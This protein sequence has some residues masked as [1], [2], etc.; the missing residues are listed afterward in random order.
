[1]SQKLFFYP[2][3]LAL[4]LSLCLALPNSALALRPN[5]IKQQ[6]AGLEALEKALGAAPNS[7]PAAGME[8]GTF[9]APSLKVLRR[10]VQPTDAELEAAWGRLKREMAVIGAYQVLQFKLTTGTRVTPEEKARVERAYSQIMSQLSW[11]KVALIIALSNRHHPFAA[12]KNFSREWA[13]S[14]IGGS[15]GIMTQELAAELAG[16]AV[17]K[18]LLGKAESGDV[19]KALDRLAKSGLGNGD[20]RKVAEQVIADIQKLRKKRKPVDGAVYRDKTA[21]LYLAALHR[22]NPG[23]LAEMKVPGENGQVRFVVSRYKLLELILSGKITD[24]SSFG[25]VEGPIRLQPGER[26]L[27]RFKSGEEVRMPVVLSGPLNLAARQPGKEARFKLAEGKDRKVVLSNSKGKKR[28]LN[29]GR[30]YK[31]PRLFMVRHEPDGESGKPVL[32]LSTPKAIQSQIEEI[33][34]QAEGTAPE[35]KL[36]GAAGEEFAAWFRTASKKTVLQYGT[37]V[38]QAQVPK[39]GL[40]IPV[41][42][43]AA[44][45]LT[46]GLMIEIPG[47]QMVTLQWNGSGFDLVSTNESGEEERQPFKESGS[48]LTVK[49]TK[50]MK[51]TQDGDAIRLQ[52]IRGDVFLDDNQMESLRRGLQW[53]S[54]REALRNHVVDRLVASRSLGGLVQDSAREDLAREVGDLLFKHYIDRQVVDLSTDPVLLKI[55]GLILREIGKER[56]NLPSRKSSEFLT[57]LYAVREGL[58]SWGTRTAAGMEELEQW[59]AL[60]GPDLRNLRGGDRVRGPDDAVRIVSYSVPMEGGE[61]EVRFLDGTQITTA[62]VESDVWFVQNNLA[63]LEETRELAD[64]DLDGL[65]QKTYR[66]VEKVESRV[67]GSSLMFDYKNRVEERKLLGVPGGGILISPNA[68]REPGAITVYVVTDRIDKNPIEPNGLIQGILAWDGKGGFWFAD[69][70]KIGEGMIPFDSEGKFGFGRGES[71][72]P[73]LLGVEAPQHISRKHVAFQSIP[74]KGLLIREEGRS[75]ARVFLPRREI[76]ELRQVSDLPRPV[77]PDLREFL[78]ILMAQIHSSNE[79]ITGADEAK[80]LSPRANALWQDL[81]GEN[82]TH[83]DAGRLLQEGR[84]L[85]ADMERLRTNLAGRLNG[86]LNELEKTIRSIR[87][88][89][90]KTALSKERERLSPQVNHRSYEFMNRQLNGLERTALAITQAASRL[91]V[92]RAQLASDPTRADDP[93]V[94]GNIK[95]IEAVFRGIGEMADLITMSDTIP[96]HG[97]VGPDG[98]LLYL[99]IKKPTE[100][101]KGDSVTLSYAFTRRGLELDLRGIVDVRQDALALAMILYNDRLP[102]AAELEGGLSPQ[103]A[104]QKAEG[105]LK[106]VSKA[107]TINLV[108]FPKRALDLERGDAVKVPVAIQGWSNVPTVLDGVRERLL[109]DGLSDYQFQVNELPPAFPDEL[110]LEIKLLSGPFEKKTSAGLEEPEKKLL[111]KFQEKGISAFD[112]GLFIGMN[113]DQFKITPDHRRELGEE[114]NPILND[115]SKEEWGLARWEAAPD[116]QKVLKAVL[117]QLVAKMDFKEAEIKWEQEPPSPAAGLEEG[118]KGRGLTRRDLLVGTVGAVLGT[119]AGV[120]GKIGYDALTTPTPQPHTP[121]PAR[122]PPQVLTP[123]PISFD[124][125][126]PVVTDEQARDAADVLCS[127][128]DLFSGLKQELKGHPLYGLRAHRLRDG[129]TKMVD[130]VDP[131]GRYV[132]VIEW[133]HPNS[134][135]D[136]GFKER[137]PKGFLVNGDVVRGLSS[138]GR[139]VL[140]RVESREYLVD[141][142]DVAEVTPTVGLLRGDVIAPLGTRMSYNEL[143]RQINRVHPDT[144][145]GIAFSLVESAELL[146]VHQKD[147]GKENRLTKVTGFTSFGGDVYVR[148]LDPKRAYTPVYLRITRKG[149]TEVAE[150]SLDAQMRQELGIMKRAAMESH[151]KT[152]YMDAPENRP[153]MEFRLG[154]PKPGDDGYLEVH[155]LD[156]GRHISLDNVSAFTVRG[157]VYVKYLNPQNSFLPEY[158]RIMRNGSLTRLSEEEVLRFAPDVAREFGLRAGMEEV[159]KTEAPVPALAAPPTAEEARDML[160]E[161]IARRVIADTLLYLIDPQRVVDVADK[162]DGLSKLAENAGYRE[163]LARM[164]PPAVLEEAFV[165]TEVPVYVQQGWLGQVTPG[166][167]DAIDKKLI[168]WAK[169]LEEAAIVIGGDN[170]SI[171]RDQVLIQVNDQTA[172]KVTAGLLQYLQ[173]Q[174]LLEPGSIVVLHRLFKGGDFGEALLIF[175]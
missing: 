165:G 5:E 65:V 85:L 112:L 12:A 175:A 166:L 134:R 79:I 6:E 62:E 72:K 46:R 76:E 4:F 107:A 86:R 153:G 58:R 154:K 13:D 110:E 61:T 126:K 54:D 167:H 138:D 50:V 136:I 97:S 16:A 91:E 108:G 18:T 105:I 129:G 73:G 148:R 130:V 122:V 32:I 143:D 80:K 157:D 160:N 52:P 43:V 131:K 137:V 40:R 34:I 77:N 146:Y 71:S 147:I 140:L 95:R 21:D 35:R 174:G 31:I 15:G 41:A 57:F 45:Q 27:F 114:F 128:F 24:Q 164:V 89:S 92:L 93:V 75:G 26:I 2:R 125:F 69:P 22:V 170:V 163:G 7:A 83:E 51:I 33:G 28:S 87:E 55:N 70:R 113:W 96:L 8:G 49:K 36:F 149:I 151:L 132:N 142:D 109:A 169:T 102:G 94:K 23:Q 63:G 14:R 156:L 20:M 117:A 118:K 11:Q 144:R 104:W 84:N 139:K 47:M 1:M 124:G 53:T 42:G 39:G 135:G 44:A 141:S 90:D 150:E 82:M 116:I 171:R 10:F 111:K 30:D 159:K 38:K 162:F 103:Q 64:L 68:L 145:L 37:V 101:I 56:Q 120:V 66:K 25:V 59:K 127:A 100:D 152:A 133:I 99:D 161:F 158:A 119:A 48:T 81:S 155:F 88:E 60:T 172:S 173:K 19:Q 17:V 78:Q 121:E 98:A 67:T 123:V 168:R 29:S 3:I 74:E 9:K 115:F 106:S